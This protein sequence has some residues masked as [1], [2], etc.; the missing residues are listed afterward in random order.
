MALRVCD[1]AHLDHGLAGGAFLQ[2]PR[3]RLNVDVSLLPE[4][5]R[6]PEHVCVWYQPP[7][8][9]ASLNT[10][11][12]TSASLVQS[13]VADLGLVCDH[14]DVTL[15]LGG[16]AVPNRFEAV[17][18]DGDEVHVCTRVAVASGAGL[19][20]ETHGGPWPLSPFVGR[21]LHTGRDQST[22]HTAPAETR[23]FSKRR[24]ENGGEEGGD[25]GDARTRA[26]DIAEKRLR[27]T[28]I[29]TE[30]GYTANLT[31]TA[32]AQLLL[33]QPGGGDRSRSARRKAL[34]R[35]RQ[36]VESFGEL[37]P[38][39]A[40]EEERID[41]AREVCVFPSPPSIPQGTV[42]TPPVELMIPSKRDVVADSNK[43][44]N[45]AER[46]VPAPGVVLPNNAALDPN[47][48]L[49][50]HGGL[51]YNW[52]EQGWVPH[53]DERTLVAIEE[54][55]RETA[56]GTAGFGGGR[57]NTVDD[58][59]SESPDTETSSSSEDEDEVKDQ[60]KHSSSSSSSDEDEDGDKTLFDK[61]KTVKTDQPV[62]FAS[63]ESLVAA[64]HR[65]ANQSVAIP[66]TQGGFEEHETSHEGDNTP[67][68]QLEPGDAVRYRYAGVSV[69]EGFE[70][71][72]SSYFQGEVIT[73]GPDFGGDLGGGVR[74]AVVIAPW[75]EERRV[76]ALRLAAI[77]AARNALSGGSETFSQCLPPPFDAYGVATIG[78]KQIVE[79]RLIG[80]PRYPSGNEHELGDVGVVLRKDV[81]EALRFESGDGGEGVAK[82][83]R[84]NQ[85]RSGDVYTSSDA[86]DRITAVSSNSTVAMLR[87]DLKERG[88]V[89][90]GTKQ[91]L[92]RRLAEREFPGM[93]PASTS[94]PAPARVTRGGDTLG[95][96][97]RALRVLRAE[98][99]IGK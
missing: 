4:N 13:I 95:G 53:P 38:F 76:E 43:N 66:G 52:P 91:V 65:L 15:R 72:Q 20:D 11:L 97:G 75:P 90:T 93:P 55:L 30:H 34:K 27:M 5:R 50:K 87:A 70:K 21:Y 62:T 25:G 46:A 36:R 9:Q 82:N 22:P 3:L 48:D 19:S 26:I 23:R 17:L 18:R 81:G 88:L 80:G 86:T 41:V 61:L 59:G 77:G 6:A 35:A 33:P 58:D 60:D 51:L 79:A 49:G 24:G 37:E 8:R 14:E 71:V 45:A 47:G 64:D 67:G 54:R 31:Q 85:P 57:T 73:V 83:T 69:D 84:P 74:L 42:V 32:P 10:S 89:S 99:H 92:L 28:P 1:M 56:G 78:T 40:T 2:P 98:G 39:V 44:K 68:D 29:D 94:T 7:P 63:L 96:M 12:N 16:Y